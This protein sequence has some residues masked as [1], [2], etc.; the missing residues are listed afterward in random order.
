MNQKE[1]TIGRFQ[2]LLKDSRDEHSQAA[3]RLREELHSLQTAL[4]NSQ[5]SYNRIKSKLHHPS[6]SNKPIQSIVSQ[7][8]CQI[9]GLEDE[10]AELHTRISNIS[11]QL[12]SCRQEADRWRILA[13]D[14][15]KNMGDLRERLEQ[16]HS[17]EL[18]TYKE[19]SQHYRLE[20]ETAKQ[21]LAVVQEQLKQQVEAAHRGPSAATQNLITV[22]K[23]QVQD[24]E[25]NEQLLSQTIADLQKQIQELVNTTNQSYIATDSKAL[26]TE[27]NN[28]RKQ[29]KMSKDEADKLRDQL[30]DRLRK[31]SIREASIERKAKAQEEVLQQKVKQLED[32]LQGATQKHNKEQSDSEARR[33]KS[34]EEVARWDERKRW[35]HTGEKLKQKLKERA[36]EVDN[37]NSTIR[38]LKDVTTRLEREKIVLD[39]RLR[40]SRNTTASDKQI[41]ALELENSKLQ[42]EVATLQSKLEMQQHHAGGLGAAMLQERLEAQQRHIAVLELA[43]KGNSTVSEELE[44]LQ[45]TNATLQKANVRLESENLE[46]RL[47]LEK[48]RADTPRLR[49]QVQHLESYISLLK[50]ETAEQ[51][52]GH[53]VA[54]NSEAEYKSKKSVA[55]LE[56]TIAALKRVVEKLQHEN[57]RLLCG[58]K[59]AIL[60]RKGSADKLK[61]ELRVVEAEKKELQEHYLEAMQRVSQLETELDK[62][63]V[64]TRLLEN[65][66]KAV[67]EDSARSDMSELQLLRAQ[68]VHKSE[69]LDKVKILLQRAAAKEKMLHDKVISLQRQLPEAPKTGTIT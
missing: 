3:A 23:S 7:Y 60:D 14:R 15:L 68:L 44:K 36:A 55:E 10:V 63:N 31:S 56:R 45:E 38:S 22:L 12:H 57:K 6:A 47:D 21:D 19:E 1:E 69:L 33:L 51:M 53:T 54:G 42:A 29:L 20:S 35:Q 66:L 27:I 49:E 39:S 24:K 8:V 41:K 30:S 48:Y 37:L 25:A 11:N 46:L 50:A 52:G 65:K 26:Q 64:Q 2:Q 4:N 67:Q 17:T 16:Q 61:A 9:Q 28:L 62:A 40:A 32:Q 43:K 34:A 13:E 58:S 5:Q 18:Q 59:N